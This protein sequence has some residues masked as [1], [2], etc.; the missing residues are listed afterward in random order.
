MR[1]IKDLTGKTF[2]GIK[3]INYFGQDKHKKAKWEVICHYR[4]ENGYEIDEMFKSDLGD[5]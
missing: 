5:E 1:K 4:Y 3:I 2:N